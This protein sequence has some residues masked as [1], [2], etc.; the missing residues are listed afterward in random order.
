M[1]QALSSRRLRQARLRLKSGDGSSR[2][3]AKALLC[4]AARDF[5]CS[6]RR[7]SVPAQLHDDGLVQ[8]IRDALRATGLPA[9]VLE[10]EI[11]ENVAL[12]QKSG[13]EP[14]HK[15]HEEGVKLAFDGFGTGYASLSYLTRLPLS[16]IQD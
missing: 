10:L 16:R 1:H 12:D 5:P 6:D 8:D 9:D 13:M 15:L 7:K 3:H 4:G 11:T 14:L 2:R